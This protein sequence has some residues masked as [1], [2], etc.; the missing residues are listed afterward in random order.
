MFQT[1]AVMILATL[2]SWSVAPPADAAPDDHRGAQKGHKPSKALPKGHSHQVAHRSKPYFSHNGRFY[3]YVN[4][5]YVTISAPIGAFIA[6]L[7]GGYV[8]FGFGANRYF[9]Y[10]DDYYRH[11]PN[12]YVVITN[13]NEVHTD[14]GSLGS[15]Q[16]IVY[17]A[18]G[19]S[20]QQT[21]SDKY[22]CHEW[23]VSDANYNPTVQDY[24]RAMGA[25]LEARGYFVK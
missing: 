15:N 23:A 20:E 16:L 18:A 2:M 3:R 8:S 19:Q 11:A 21:I 7:P 14:P 6:A 25:C 24:Q 12:G 22:E 13:P 5:S 4:G 9:Q 10:G 1:T 17:P